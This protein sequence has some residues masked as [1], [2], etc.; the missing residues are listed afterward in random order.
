MTD[1]EP[2]PR[3]MTRQNESPGSES[4]PQ[5][6][7][8]SEP[9]EPCHLG[10][11]FAFTQEAGGLID[12]LAGGIDIAGAGFTVREGGL[13][14]RRVAVI[15]SGAG[16]KAAARATEILIAGHAPKCVISSG[17][18]GGLAE[19]I[20][21]GDIVIASDLIDAQGAQAT[22]DVPSSLAELATTSPS[23]DSKQPLVHIGRAITV[24][25]IVSTPEAKRQLAREHN[26]IAVDMESLAVAQT[27]SQHNTPFLAI[28]IISDAAGD[29]LPAEVTNLVSQ[30]SLAGQLGA[31]TGALFKRPSSIKDIYK[32]KEDALLASDNLAKFL[33]STSRNWKIHGPRSI[34]NIRW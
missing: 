34:A 13:A 25:Q 32:L 10:F 17:F 26:A 3:D 6:Q 15:V 9:Q 4:R 23:P 22:I 27:C 5:D 33:E 24:D 14:G 1:P 7:T 2:K 19:N 21:R 8:A 11:V 18:A 16:R 12:R 28:R 29:T 31:L 20:A 30:K